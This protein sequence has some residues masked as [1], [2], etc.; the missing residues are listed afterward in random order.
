[1]T[2]YHF[3]KMRETAGQG[4]WDMRMRLHA[5]PMTRTIDPSVLNDREV[6]YIR[7]MCNTGLYNLRDIAER[8][9]VTLESARDVIKHCF[10][11]EHTA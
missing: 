11:N 10:A 6:D 4:A 8:W 9:N 7:Q 1:M 2:K 3:T 5:D